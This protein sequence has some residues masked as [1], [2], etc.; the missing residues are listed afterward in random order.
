ME[1]SLAVPNIGSVQE[2]QGKAGEEV[3]WCMRDK[4]QLYY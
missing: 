3:F 1:F 2:G 4:L